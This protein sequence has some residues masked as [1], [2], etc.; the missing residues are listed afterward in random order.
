MMEMIANNEVGAIIV[1][2]LSRFARKLIQSEH[3]RLLCA[4][5]NTLIILEGRIL[6]PR[7][8]HDTASLQMRASQAELDN[9]ERADYLQMCRVSK[10]MR[11]MVVSNIPI[12]YLRQRNGGWDK[13]PECLNII[14]RIFSAFRE[15]R[16][17][18]ATVKLLL[19]E[20]IQ[21]PRYRRSGL[22]FKPARYSAIHCILRN[23][24]YTG[25]YFYRRT[26]SA[27]ELDPVDTGQSKRRALP[28]DQWIK[29]TG[30]FPPYITEDEHE[31]I[32][33]IILGNKFPES[34]FKGKGKALVQGLLLCGN[35]GG[36]LNI[37]YSGTHR[38][39]RYYCPRGIDSGKSACLTTP[40]RSLDALVEE[41]ILRRLAS[42]KAERLEFALAEDRKKDAQKAA[43]VDEEQRRLA[44]K[45]DS[46]HKIFQRCGRES[47]RVFKKAEEDFEQAI[48][49]LEDFE[50][51]ITREVKDIARQISSQELEE[52]VALAKKI[53]TLWRNAKF[54]IEEKKNIIGCLVKHIT[55]N[56][57]GKELTSGAIHW[58]TGFET[59][60]RFY[61]SKIGTNLVKELWQEGCTEAEI[62]QK[63]EKG[64]TSTHQRIQLKRD[65]LTVILKKFGAKLPRQS[66]AL[67]QAKEQILK[68]YA[69][70]VPT[71]DIAEHLNR[72]GYKR[73]TGNLWDER[74]VFRTLDKAPKRL[75]SL[76][77]QQ[78]ELLL[79]ARRRGLSFSKIAEEF[80]RMDIPRL[81]SKRPWTKVAVQQRFRYFKRLNKQT[82]AA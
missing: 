55:V 38:Y 33:K 22:E 54:T 56:S 62:L 5:H 41:E 2:H 79:D 34:R 26:E 47:P 76:Q 7:D 80:N 75:Y 69:K 67:K 1:G 58:K 27:I 36:K 43:L 77:K 30:M 42:P 61:R 16:S 46:A 53:P 31:E 40:G 37:N 60:Y 66:L 15:T 9:A 74:S 12:G 39:P 52:L 59:P 64:E 73:A 70:G 49:A 20:G 19:S 29:I 78:L 50:R 65:S 18:R 3:L 45:M 6:N 57:V 17:I 14:E 4:K 32:L 72:L 82:G 21:V 28:K 48:K 81:K 8:R 68:L 63:L 25:T 13:D 71:K 24:I 23:P 44:R 35:C 11:G 10:A 51:R